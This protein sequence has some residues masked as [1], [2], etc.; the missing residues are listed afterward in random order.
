M[1]ND[2]EDYLKDVK[3]LDMTNKEVR[4]ELD[5]LNREEK[6]PEVKLTIET[7]PIKSAKFEELDEAIEE[8]DYSKAQQI[9]RDL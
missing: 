8:G 4:R 5:E 1:S 3:D 9:K 7:D 2:Y 6:S